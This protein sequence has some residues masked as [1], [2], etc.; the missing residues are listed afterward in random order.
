MKMKII[1]GP[2]DTKLGNI[3][4]VDKGIGDNTQFIS[5]KTEKDMTEYNGG[6]QWRRTEEKRLKPRKDTLGQGTIK[7]KMRKRFTGGRTEA[8]KG[9][10]VPKGYQAF[11]GVEDAMSRLT[12]KIDYRTVEAKQEELASS[13]GPVQRTEF[14]N[15]VG[16]VRQFRKKEQVGGLGSDRMKQAIGNTP[17]NTKKGAPRGSATG[18]PRRHNRTLE[19]GKTMQRKRCRQRKNSLG[20]TMKNGRERK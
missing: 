10:S 3:Q 11:C 16:D 18:E 20:E 6:R 17:A 8:S 1:S 9:N 7:E 13:R 2:P 5:R 14:S 15:T 19:R 12:P 4:E